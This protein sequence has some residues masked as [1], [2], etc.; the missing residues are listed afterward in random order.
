ML[1]IIMFSKQPKSLINPYLNAQHQQQNP[2]L[3]G[4]LK[5]PHLKTKCLCKLPGLIQIAS[6]KLTNKFFKM[7]GIRNQNSNFII[8]I[9]YL[10]ISTQLIVTLKS[11]QFRNQTQISEEQRHH[12]PRY[13]KIS[14]LAISYKHN[15]LNNSKKPSSQKHNLLS[16]YLQC[17]P[18]DI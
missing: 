15:Y 16:K 2:L 9:M 5:I 17:C 14:K 3:T 10:T 8:H 18:N 6:P 11:K 13:K 1:L 4:N 7:T 12:Q